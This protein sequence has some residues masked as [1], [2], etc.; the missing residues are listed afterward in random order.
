MTGQ[1]D[2]RSFAT[3]LQKQKKLI[4]ILAAAFAVLIAAYFIFIAPLTGEETAPPDAFYGEVV[5]N[6][7]TIQMLPSASK[8]N[9]KS[10]HIHSSYADDDYTIEYDGEK[11]IFR[12]VSDYDLSLDSEQF[13]ALV[14]SVGY[15]VTLQHPD[16]EWRIS[17]ADDN[18]STFGF[19]PEAEDMSY[20]EVETRE[21][22]VSGDENQ[23]VTSKYRVFIG[24]RIP[25]GGGYYAML[26]GRRDADGNNVIYILSGDYVKQVLGGAYMVLSTLLTEVPGNDIYYGD[27]VY[28]IYHGF[29]DEDLYA[30][31]CTASELQR[32]YSSTHAYVMEYPGAYF[33]NEE[34]F[35]KILDILTMVQGDE[36]IAYGDELT[37]ELLA[38]HYG[39]YIGSCADQDDKTG[40]KLRYTSTITESGSTRNYEETLYISRLFRGSSDEYYYVYSPRYHVLSTM[41]SSNFGFVEWRMNILSDNNLISMNIWSAQKISL[42]DAAADT[43]Y[44]FTKEPESVMGV[45]AGRVIVPDGSPQGYY[46]F[47]GTYTVGTKVEKNGSVTVNEPIT[48]QF[49]VLFNK[50]GTEIERK[51]IGRFQNFREFFKSLI[52]RSST[53]DATLDKYEMFGDPVY[54]LEIDSVPCDYPLSMYRYDTDGNPIIDETY[55]T[56]ASFKYYGG[57][58]IYYT[59]NAD[60]SVNTYYYEDAYTGELFKYI[61]DTI[62]NESRPKFKRTKAGDYDERGVDTDGD[63]FNDG[64]EIWLYAYD[65]TSVVS[66]S[67]LIKNG[68]SL[69]NQEII[70]EYKF[71]ELAHKVTDDVNSS[72]LVVIPTVSTVTYK[73]GV[74]ISRT[75]ESPTEGVPV[76]R[77]VVEKLVKAA[78]AVIYDRADELTDYPTFEYNTI[79]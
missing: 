46:Y 2:K 76:L 30:R 37:D 9:I 56:Q 22:L 51:S 42:Y 10:I 72:Y 65:P 66:R 21:P 57:N 32:M 74:E 17:C 23:Y 62:V 41:T 13:E 20:F 63:P 54:V 79:N 15:L 4:I 12:F 69:Y 3:L 61:N 8:S 1:K 7:V 39:I 49:N 35:S 38:E 6:E 36:I 77:S 19:L 52:S 33:V 47:D 24:D 70:Y 18:L 25:S 27:L 34:A 50:Y 48:E 40:Y 75:V 28:E 67:T 53:Q 71:Y 29:A 64:P 11:G 78:N 14:V 5:A 60:G 44:S 45:T 58:K 16:G 43:K 68:F 26:E 59:L 31:I 55:G 73:D